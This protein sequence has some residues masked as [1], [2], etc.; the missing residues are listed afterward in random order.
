MLRSRIGRSVTVLLLL[1]AL[2][3]VDL[4]AQ[5][6][7]R[8]TGEVSLK[9]SYGSGTASE[10][11]S[12]DG[13]RKPY[14]DNV[15]EN[16]YFDRSLY[17]YT[18][19]GVT[20]DLTLVASL[21]YKRIVLRDAAF[22]Y[23]TFAFGDLGVAGR[24]SLSELI[25]FTGGPNAA[26]AT[27]GVSIPLGYTRNYTPSVGAGQMNLEGH[28]SYGRSFYPLPAYLQTSLGYRHRSAIFATSTAVDCAEGIDR[29]CV[30]D[31]RPVFGDEL[32]GSFE[33]GVTLWQRLLLQ[34][35]VNTTWSVREPVTGF[36][37][38]N[39]V[40][41]HQRFVRVG[42]GLALLLPAGI[43]LSSQAFQTVAGQSSLRSFELFFALDITIRPF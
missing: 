13:N 1:P 33:T 39:P 35:F 37:V 2:A 11:F 32:I 14:A 10:Q 24:Y 30:E 26:A 19:V 23:R 41:T 43:T 28:L 17:L 40:P 27:V 20:P 9:L 6:W 12:F 25:G 5:A 31:R 36:T 8:D 18:E 16:S 42:G 7:T 22:R 21:P 34:S 38:A 15:E 4:G 29:D 3:T